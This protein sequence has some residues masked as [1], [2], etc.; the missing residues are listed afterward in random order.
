MAP[1]A[2]DQ[3]VFRMPF[4]RG[5]AIL[6]VMFF[7]IFPAEPPFQWHS[8]S[9]W[10]F[11]AADRLADFGVPVFVLMSGFYLSLNER[12]E[13]PRLL[14][15]RTLKFLIVPYIAYSALYAVPVVARGTTAGQLLHGF[16]TASIAVHLWFVPLILEL[17]LLHPA[18]R[19]LYRRQPVLTVVAACLLQI[20]WPWFR[21]SGLLSWNVSRVPLWF[22]AEVAYFVG[23]YVLLDRAESVS[24]VATSRG[25][26]VTAAAVW[27][28]LGAATT[29]IRVPGPWGSE[30]LREMADH[31]LILG[32][33]DLARTIAAF[34]VVV[35]VSHQLD[36]RAPWAAARVSRFGL[37]SYGVYYLHPIA[38]S[39]STRAV[40][41]ATGLTQQQVLWYLAVF[42]ITAPVSLLMT[43]WLSRYQVARYLM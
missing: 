12:N 14:Y 23:G 3:F 13:K 30:G 2:R 4:V 5:A 41:L 38:I 7:H 42:L 8:V 36:A 15:R 33:A 1:S 22:C 11:V 40:T 31:Q 20:S 32:L 25:G 17:Y 26:I 16:L 35:G 39:I 43:R 10:L 21:D 24:R 18:L 37:Y 34:L 27:I 29:F 28:G 6:A 19:R 9:A